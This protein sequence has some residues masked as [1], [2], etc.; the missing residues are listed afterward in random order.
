M[1]RGERE[2]QARLR[3]IGQTRT[4]MKAIQIGGVRE[5]KRLVPRRT[6]NLGRTI[7]FGPVTDTTCA[8]EAGGTREVGYAAVVERGSRP[9]TI[10]P[11]KA[12]VLAWGGER[13]LGGRLRAGARPTNFARSVRHPGQ[14][15]QPYLVPGLRKGAEEEGITALVESWNRAD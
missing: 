12:K 13:T 3:A 9:H 4:M 8:I 1:V 10:V 5:A 2:L 6:S 15:A 14:R 11:R 7:R